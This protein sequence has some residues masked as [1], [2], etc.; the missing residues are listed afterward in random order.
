[1]NYVSVSMVDTTS[2][3]PQPNEKLI[4]GPTK[5]PKL[6]LN[7]YLGFLSRHGKENTILHSVYHLAKS[8]WLEKRIQNIAEEKPKQKTNLKVSLQYD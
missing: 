7:R 3:K 2:N 1:M 5:K 4:M 8:T 6:L